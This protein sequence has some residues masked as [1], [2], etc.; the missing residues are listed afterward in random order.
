MNASSRAPEAPRVCFLFGGPALYIG[1]QS[2]HGA[3]LLDDLPTSRLVALSALALG[4]T[5][6]PAAPAHL[7]A[8]VAA[9][10]VVTLVTFDS[11]N[12][13][14]DAPANPI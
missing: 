11:R 9:M 1:A 5:F 7:A 12:L 4:C 13:P 6:T 8:V 3:T 14:E 10:S 2:W